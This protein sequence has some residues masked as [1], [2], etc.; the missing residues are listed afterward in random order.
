MVHAVALKDRK[1]GLWV[2]FQFRRRGSPI[3][4]AMKYVLP[5]YRTRIQAVI[6]DTY[7]DATFD[8]L[9]EGNLYQAY[10]A[11]TESDAMTQIGSGIGFDDFVR[12]YFPN[13]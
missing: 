5:E 11:L 6:L 1:S 7:T 13:S 8:V 9:M 12:T 3:E 10:I 2:D 4:G